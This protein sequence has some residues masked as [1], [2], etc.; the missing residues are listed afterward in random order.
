MSMVFDNLKTDMAHNIVIGAIEAEFTTPDGEPCAGAQYVLRLS[1]GTER[2]GTLT[3]E[4]KLRETNLKPGATASIR[5]V[6]I[7]MLAKAE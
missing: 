6:G 2:K 4:G 3:S 5:L 7:P 1:D